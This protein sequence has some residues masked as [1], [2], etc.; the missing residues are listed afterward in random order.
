LAVNIPIPKAG[1]IT[2]LSPSDECPYKTIL[3]DTR[4]KARVWL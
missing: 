3:V 4:V 2:C 1:F